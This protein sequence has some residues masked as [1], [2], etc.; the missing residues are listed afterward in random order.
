[1]QRD[2][3]QLKRAILIGS[4]I[5]IVVYLLWQLLVL[6]AVPQSDLI[7]AYR[8]GIPSTQP[9]ARVLQSPLIGTAAQL[10]AFFAIV[11]SFVGVTMSLADF[12]SDGLKI[13]NTHSGRL[14]ALLLTF[15]PPLF[16]VLTY[17]KGFY[18]ALDY[19]GVF[20]AVLLIFLPAAMAWKLKSYRSP[21]RRLILSSL[22]LIAI[23]IVVLD[24][25]KVSGKLSALISNY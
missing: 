20:V 2:R 11:T 25:L 4:S 17:Q 10:F 15:L 6:G 1:M 18:V 16:F 14:I 22:F 7:A 13:K 19:A 24:L 8:Q 23:G 9:L 21:L 5:P 3:T 12:L